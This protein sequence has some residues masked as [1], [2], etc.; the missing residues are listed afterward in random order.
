MD[1]LQYY[2]GLIFNSKILDLSVHTSSPQQNIITLG[3]FSVAE[4]VGV[5]NTTCR[6]SFMGLQPSNDYGLHNIFY[7]ITEQ[8]RVTS[9]SGTYGKST[10]L[11]TVE[12]HVADMVRFSEDIKDYSWKMFSKSF[13]DQ[14]DGILEEE[15]SIIAE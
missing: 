10:C 1:E 5:V 13:D 14:L 15:L 8:A 3:S 4:I 2:L 7:G 9:T 11:W 12:F 6:I